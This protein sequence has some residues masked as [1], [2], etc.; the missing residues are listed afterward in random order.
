MMPQ[1]IEQWHNYGL[2]DVYEG[3]EPV[4]WSM[5]GL[6]NWGWMPTGNGRVSAVASYGIIDG[7][8]LGGLCAEVDET[9]T[10]EGTDGLVRTPMIELSLGDYQYL[11]QNGTPY[12]GMLGLSD[13][14]DVYQYDGLGG[15]FRKLFRR[16]RG[17]VRKVRRRIRKG[18]RKLLSKSK[19][20]RFL[21]KVGGKIKSIAMK[22][23]RPLMKFVGKWAGKLAPIAAMIPGYG[24]AVAAALTA[25]GRVANVMKKWGVSTHGKKGA[26]RT[27]KFKDPKKFPAFQKALKSEAQRMK[28]L[29][30]SNPKKFHELSTALARRK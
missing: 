30:K 14:G 23:V 16:V 18:I 4:E 3:A 21:L 11:Q 17:A 8:M 12:N 19:F 6:N 22:I 5:L 10:W 27:L 20:G 25:A 13:T 1:N 2:G 26:V 15:F 29:S 9:D 28:A 24:T 7:A